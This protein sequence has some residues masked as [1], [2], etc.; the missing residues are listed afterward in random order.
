ML[1]SA[2]SRGSD[3][4]WSAHKGTFFMFRD[5]TLLSFYHVHTGR[6]CNVLYLHHVDSE[7]SWEERKITDNF[8]CLLQTHERVVCSRRHHLWTDY[9]ERG[10]GTDDMSLCHL[11]HSRECVQCLLHWKP[12]VLLA[13]PFW[14][15][16]PTSP[17]RDTRCISQF[18]WRQNVFNPDFSRE[19][20]ILFLYFY[21][22]TRNVE[23]CV[24]CLAVVATHIVPVT[25][26]TIT[27]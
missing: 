4:G 27:W 21:M 19:I 10:K 16:F 12:A 8:I 22:R 14:P 24:I 17:W 20:D 26:E 11:L 23:V 5:A 1:S 3:W 6:L 25:F 18:R 7:W 15:W 9:V 13:F 2:S